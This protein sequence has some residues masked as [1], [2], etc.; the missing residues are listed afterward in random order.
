VTEKPLINYIVD[1]GK[2][3]NGFFGDLTMC[4]VPDSLLRQFMRTVICP[5]YPRGI[6]EALQDLMKKEVQKQ[7][8][9]DAFVN[10]TNKT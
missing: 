6:S 1:N 8:K 3:R 9:L 10:T 2:S 5:K 4:N 7:K